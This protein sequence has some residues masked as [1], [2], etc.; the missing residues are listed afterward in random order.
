[1]VKRPDWR[2]CDKDRYQEAITTKLK[3]IDLTAI[4][5][6]TEA[7]EN[8]ENILHHAG[9]LSIPKYRKQSIVTTKGK[10][11]W[12]QDI[13]NASRKSKEAF[14]IWK[15]DIQNQE[16]KNEMHTAKRRL[17][18]AQRRA[19]DS[20]RIALTEKI[21]KSSQS[22]NKLFHKLIQ[23]Q[24]RSETTHPDIM[25]FNKNAIDD[26]EKISDGWRDYF[27]ELFNYVIENK[28]DAEKLILEKI[29]NEIIESIEKENLQPIERATVD[30]VQSS[31]CKMKT[32]KSP[33]VN[34]ISSEHFKYGPEEIVPFIVFI[35]N[36][37]FDNLDVPEKIK[38][39]T[40][41]SVLKTGK[42]KMYPENYRG[43]TVT[44]TFS[45]VL[46][47][48]LKDRIEPALLPKQSTAWF[49]GKGIITKYSVYCYTNSRLL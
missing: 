34:G 13:N 43:I 2:K 20:Q 47:S 19:H 11:I 30:E 9:N 14:Y 10:S 33:D 1:M 32:G 4:K 37:I 8:L 49:H 25:V 31:I 3:E 24:R 45:T 12:N 28:I 26:P 39:G 44:N 42:D 23:N 35:I 46:E 38:S 36:L 17:R 7:I 15:Q 22:D 18:S 5:T 48:I 6:T 40:V 41:T 27:L 29:Q 16:L 21:M